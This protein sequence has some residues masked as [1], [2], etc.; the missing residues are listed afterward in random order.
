[1]NTIAWIVTKFFLF[2]NGVQIKVQNA[3]NA[4]QKILKR[5]FH[6]LVARVLLIQARAAQE[7]RRI[8]V[9]AAV[10]EDLLFAKP[11]V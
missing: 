4:G 7:V 2:Y 6:L 9:S 10:V 5:N 1:M 3:R 11:C 8:L